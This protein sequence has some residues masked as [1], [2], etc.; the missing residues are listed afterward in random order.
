M[1]LRTSRKVLPLEKKLSEKRR[2]WMELTQQCARE[3]ATHD[4]EYMMQHSK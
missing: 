3:V 1:Q 2:K 4:W